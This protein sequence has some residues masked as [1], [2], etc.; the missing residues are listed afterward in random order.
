MKVSLRR[1]LQVL[2]IGSTLLSW[3]ISVY[4]TAFFAR[5]TIVEQ[6]DRQL[7][8]YLDMIEWAIASNLSVPPE[9]LHSNDLGVPAQISDLIDLHHIHSRASGADLVWSIWIGDQLVTPSR[10][11]VVLPRL[12]TDSPDTVSLVSHGV[13]KVLRVVSRFDVESS[14]EI[15]VGIDLHQAVD[16]PDAWTGRSVLPLFLILPFTLVLLWWSVNKGL[17]PLTSLMH[18]VERRNAS[19]LEPIRADHLPVEVSSLADAIN[20]LLFKLERALESEVRFTA[21]AAH[22]LQTPLAS[23]QAEVQ[24]CQRQYN[25]PEIAEMLDRIA[26]R[27]RLGTDTIKQLLTL[28][29][30]DPEQRFIPTELI[31]NQ[32]ALDVLAEM[33]D[34]ALEKELDL[35]ITDSRDISV[36][37]HEGWVVIMLRNLIG[38]AIKYSPTG[39]IL[40]LNWHK[41]EDHVIFCVTNS[42]SPIPEKLLPQLTDRFF[43]LPEAEGS[44][45]GLG[46]SIVKRIASLLGVHFEL[47]MIGGGDV[48]KAQLIFPH[49]EA[50]SATQLADER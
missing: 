46:L 44:G 34:L 24:R 15:S 27:V 16:S 22:E 38:N 18:Q 17:A 37:G 35:Q 4:V 25:E 13:T 5:S 33:A 2:V 19:D 21:N 11:A 12:A 30:L 47:S 8:Q 45:V 40:S 6:V 29:R 31:L 7:Y 23:I 28:A 32:L 10:D 42:A 43:T 50:A 20:R 36:M 14:P 26:S 9:S 48:F 41:S 39:G 49:S 1:R 3:F